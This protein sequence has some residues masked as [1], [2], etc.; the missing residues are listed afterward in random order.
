[1]A[2]RIR[3]YFDPLCPWCYQTSRWARRLDELGVVDVEWRVFSLG[4]VNGG[5]EGRTVADTGS[6]PSL[7]TAIAV[8][9]A[10]GNAAVGAFYKAV[11]DAHHLR[12][13]SLDD[14]AVIRAAL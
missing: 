2:E 6:A 7:R 4:I 3:F 1:M 14:P 8:R 5:D 10:S 11:S 13:A 9:N 12:G